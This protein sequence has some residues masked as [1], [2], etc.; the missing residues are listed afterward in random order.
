MSA[1]LAGQRALKV[2]QRLGKVSTVCLVACLAFLHGLLLWQRIESLTLLQPMVALRWGF[3]VLA[4]AGFV[5]QQRAEGSVFRGR[6]ALILWLLVLV[7]HA[8][9]LPATEPGMLLLL[10]LW[11]AALLLSGLGGQVQV[12]RLAPP[13]PADRPRISGGAWFEPLSPRPPPAASAI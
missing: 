10:S 7:L 4:L 9:T 11:G 8:G 2:R 1:R 3:A 5:Q 13:P 6:K 12:L